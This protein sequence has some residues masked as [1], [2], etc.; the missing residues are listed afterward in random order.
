[1]L[2]LGNIYHFWDF[3]LLNDLLEAFFFQFRAKLVKDFT[4]FFI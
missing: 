4:F 2:E 3:L 1:M